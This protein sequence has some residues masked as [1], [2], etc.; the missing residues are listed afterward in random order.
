MNPASMPNG[1]GLIK[2]LILIIR[3]HWHRDHDCDQIVAWPRDHRSLKWSHEHSPRLLVTQPIDLVLEIT[4]SKTNS[5]GQPAS[6]PAPNVV[7]V[8]MDNISSCLHPLDEAVQT[9]V[10]FW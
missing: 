7:G 10:R 6:I 2:T 3:G 8:L 1:N 5:V 4:H 9:A